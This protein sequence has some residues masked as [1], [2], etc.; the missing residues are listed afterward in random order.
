MSV[1]IKPVKLTIA[2]AVS[3]PTHGRSRDK[4]TP[5]EKS[6]QK[7]HVFLSKPRAKKWAED[8]EC[9]CII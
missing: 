9:A 5:V 4:M 6:F 8:K 2:K 7:L 3:P 1:K